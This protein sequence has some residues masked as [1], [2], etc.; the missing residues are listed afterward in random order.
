MSQNYRICSS[1]SSNQVENEKET[2]PTSLQSHGECR[3]GEGGLFL[4][5]LD[6]R[7]LASPR[8]T[9]PFL[10]RQPSSWC[11]KLRKSSMPWF[12]SLRVQPFF[13]NWPKKL[14]ETVGNLEPLGPLLMTILKLFGYWEEGREQCLLWGAFNLM[15][16][17]LY[18]QGPKI[19]TPSLRQ[20]ALRERPMPKYCGP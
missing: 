8:S 10:R 16:K 7:L 2:T 5:R 18:F 9:L 13:P 4:G 19:W 11:H 12:C 15:V 20:S 17:K 1:K 6:Q 14:W 3:D